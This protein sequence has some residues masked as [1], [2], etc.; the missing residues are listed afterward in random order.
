MSDFPKLLGDVG[1]TNARLALQSA[2]GAPI[3]HIVNLACGDFAGP[4]EAIV[5]YL[6]QVLPLAGCGVP[7][8]GVIGIANPILGDEVKMTNAHW[9]FS[10]SRLR[11]ALGLSS[12]R[13]I[14]DFTALALS[15]PA[16]PAHELKQ[17]GG[18]EPM[19]GKALALV[20]AGTGLGVSGL[21]PASGDLWVP[22]E[23][24]G[25]HVTLPAFDADE[26]R[27]IEVLRTLFPH[28]SAERALSGPGLVALY[29]AHAQL[30]GAVPEPLSPADVSQ[31]GVEGSCALC[32]AALNSFCA[33]LGTVA[34]D[35]AVTLGA[36]GGVYVGGGVVPR[37]G[38]FF[39]R[40]PFRARFESKGRF[41][42]YLQRIPVYVIHSP[43]PALIGASR[44]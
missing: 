5:H 29:H 24:E 12:L 17:V 2:P 13:F 6:E 14:N 3:E 11:D 16:L 27:V 40:S 43:F 25:G 35:L 22:I 34:A 23:G 4:R 41:G 39:E 44:A 38:A 28:V 37:L 26:T 9:A 18:G 10:I 8:T 21:I 19:P 32:V 33:M 1:G 30:Q 36:Q 7:R 20:G 15:L 31:R 42:P